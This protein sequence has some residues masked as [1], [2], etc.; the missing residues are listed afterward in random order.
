MSRYDYRDPGEDPRYCDGLS[1]EPGCEE[2]GREPCICGADMRDSFFC[3]WCGRESE[4]QSTYPYC[5]E[6]CDIDAANDEPDE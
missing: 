5:S 3:V 4:D 2:C 6:I 1:A